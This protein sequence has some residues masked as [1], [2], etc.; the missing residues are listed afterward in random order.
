MVRKLRGVR[1]WIIG[2][3]ALGG[4]LN[5]LTRSTLSVAA[6]TILATLHISDEGVFLDHRCVPGDDHAAAHRGLCAGRHRP[7]IR[8]GAVLLRLV[9]DLH[10]AR[11][12]DESGRP[13]PG[14]GVRWGWPKDRSC[15]PA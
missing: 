10:G 4:M 13:S 9:A 1:W 2:L 8:R 5:Y 6:P 3:V 15:R 11:T 14:C 12:G 7:Q